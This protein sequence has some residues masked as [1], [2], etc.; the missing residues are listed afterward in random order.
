MVKYKSN[1]ETLDLAFSALAHP[2]RREILMFLMNGEASVIQLAEPFQMSLPGISKHLK[3]LEKAGLIERSKR[4]Q[5]R[6]CKIK[7]EPLKEI[8]DWLDQ[9]K[10]LWE[11]RFNQ[12][13]SYLNSLK[14][15]NQK[16]NK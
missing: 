14:K 6:P 10:K 12:L 15:Q 8:N 9:Y 3:V 5:W 7:L 4:A 13:D 16:E 11:T 2:A 1:S